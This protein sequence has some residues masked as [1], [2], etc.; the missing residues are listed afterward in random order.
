ML[1]GEN[2]HCGSA[3]AHCSTTVHSATKLLKVSTQCA[4]RLLGS[5]ILKACDATALSSLTVNRGC[6][7]SPAEGQPLL[8]V[9]PALLLL[10]LPAV[11]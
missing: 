11:T 4:D 2:P 1:D 9:P 7:A 6:F 3:A 5:R 8:A 10:E